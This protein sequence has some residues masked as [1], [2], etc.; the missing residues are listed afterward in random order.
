MG[1]LYLSAT[2]W[3]GILTVSLNA[4]TTQTLPKGQCH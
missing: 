2:L 3:L 4:Q 1:K